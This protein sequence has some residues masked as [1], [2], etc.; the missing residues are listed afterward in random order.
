MQQTDMQRSTTRTM[1][2][3]LT[4]PRYF[5]KDT[6]FPRLFTT[7]N[8]YKSLSLLSTRLSKVRNTASTP[9]SIVT[10][11]ANAAAAAATPASAAADNFDKLRKVPTIATPPPEVISATARKRTIF[12]AVVVKLKL[13]C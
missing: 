11:S 2:P 5:S 3:R 7:L 12:Y 10:Q 13:S 4:E 9:G 8:V 6:N 1:I